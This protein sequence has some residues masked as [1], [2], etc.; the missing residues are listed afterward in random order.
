ERPP[1]AVPRERG[2]PLRR[3]EA[4]QELRAAGAHHR[5]PAPRRRS[6]PVRRE[7]RRRGG[8]ARPDLQ[9]R[10]GRVRGRRRRVLQR[11]H[12]CRLR[13]LGGGHR[14]R[15]GPAGRHR[16]SVPGPDPRPAGRRPRL[17]PGPEV[18][19]GAPD[20]APRRGPRLR[21]TPP[22]RPARHR[23]PVPDL[24]RAVLRHRPRPG[25]ADRCPVQR[26]DGD[27]RHR[28]AHPVLPGL[29]GGRGRRR[30]PVRPRAVGG[31]PARGGRAGVHVPH[32]QRRPRH[33]L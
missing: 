17:L 5:G 18:E 4:R 28:A 23:G 22:L 31:D 3:R 30:L 11:R 27:R 20:L 2:V 8:G 1:A 10:H 13:V 12:D 16:P 6:P 15:P 33:R 9:P 29:R 19:P 26:P 24:L 25:R 14:G 7:P 32:A 21:R